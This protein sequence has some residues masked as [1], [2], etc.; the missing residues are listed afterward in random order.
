[1]ASLQSGPAASAPA[2]AAQNG[3]SILEA[4]ANMARQNTTAAAPGPAPSNGNLPA[5]AASYT[6]PA[7]ALPQPVASSQQ[8]SYPAASQPVNAPS[9]PFNMAQMF[10]QNAQ[11]A[12]SNPPQQVP[13]APAGAPAMDQNTQQQVMLIKLLAEQGVPFDK[14]PALIQSMT[15]GGAQPA[16][17]PASQGS[18]PA[19][20]SWG[21]P[22]N[23]SGHNDPRDRGYGDGNRSPQRYRGG[24]SRSRSPDRWGGQRGGRDYGGRNSPPRGRD[25]RNG[26]RGNDYRQ[27]S[28]PGR[29]GR[30]PSPG[31][32]PHI[33]RWAEYDSSLPPNCI[34]VLSRTLFV[35]GVT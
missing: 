3:S 31:E 4:L 6:M 10:G 7:S 25:D 8:P 32:F 29:R 14:I 27:R 15:S 5:P 28:P 2:P 26:R 13:G 24:R 12:A 19:Q 35:G 11:P 34:R 23:G 22:S 1:M 20:P 18:F 16:P 17:T 33:E 21:A 30:S 9:A